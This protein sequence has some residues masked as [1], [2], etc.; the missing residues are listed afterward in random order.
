MMLSFDIDQ[1]QSG[2]QADIALIREDSVV[3]LSADEL[4]NKLKLNDWW[5]G[6][7]SW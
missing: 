6:S 2:K 7:D 1:I 3:V 5:R 4:R